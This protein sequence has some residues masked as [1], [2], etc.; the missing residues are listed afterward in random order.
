MADRR[1]VLS[2][3]VTQV[4]GDPYPPGPRGDPPTP[5]QKNIDFFFRKSI[6][7][8]KNSKKN[9]A[10]EKNTQ[11]FPQTELIISIPP[12]AGRNIYQLAISTI[13]LIY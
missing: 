9:F 7:L 13:W 6:D 8:K 3:A 10:R 2:R 1:S 11:N 5:P 4:G 12:Y